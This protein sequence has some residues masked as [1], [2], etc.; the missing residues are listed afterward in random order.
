MSSHANALK[1][2]VFTARGA[3]KRVNTGFKPR[4]VVIRNVTD[5]ISQEKTESMPADKA[6][7]TL[8]DGTRTY[9]DRVRIESDGFTVLAAA[10]I[11]GKELH[12]EAYQAENEN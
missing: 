9:V 8:A 2:G 5:G 11:D 4:K 1:T 10:A 3:D 6:S 7:N 12:Y